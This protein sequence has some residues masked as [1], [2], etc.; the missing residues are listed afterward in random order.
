M[1]AHVRFW[2]KVDMHGPIYKP[3]RT[4][5]W[6][7]TAGTM[8]GYGWFRV[9]PGVSTRAH[10][11]ALTLAGRPV[12]KGKIACHRCNNRLCVR[13]G[14]LYFGTKATNKQ[15][16][17][18]AGTHVHGSTHPMSK[19]TEARV[20]LIRRLYAERKATQTE[21]AARFGVSTRVVSAAIRRVSWKHVP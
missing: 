8:G 6:I 10:T 2:S 19:L 11:Y 12:P 16:S 1:V 13:P 3:Q 14:H 15:D 4:R 7:W 20:R 18:L 5:C 17:V 21:L 9:R